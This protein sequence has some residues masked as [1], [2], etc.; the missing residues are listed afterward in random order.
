MRGKEIT[1]C[2]SHIAPVNL[3]DCRIMI[4]FKKKKEKKKKKKERNLVTFSS[5]IQLTHNGLP[6]RP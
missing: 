6:G 5:R 4:F 3:T 1:S 2:K